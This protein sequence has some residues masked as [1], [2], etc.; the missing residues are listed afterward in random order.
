MAPEPRTIRAYFE[1]QLAELRGSLPSVLA[2][3]I[4][5]EDAAVAAAND[6]ERLSTVTAQ[7]RVL[8]ETARQ[9]SGDAGIGQPRCV[10][11]DALGGILIVRPIATARPRFIVL[12]LADPR[13]AS[14]ALAGV[15]RLANEVEARLAPASH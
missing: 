15:H 5:C 13:D 6:R 2:A 9:A 7:V 10:I 4:V 12:L 3:A 1:R 8:V 14:R 11:V